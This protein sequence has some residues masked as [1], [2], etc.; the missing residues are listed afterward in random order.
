MAVD[1][2]TIATA[3]YGAGAK[4]PPGPMSQLLWIWDD[5]VAVLPYDTVAAANAL[6]AAG[7][8]RGSDGL[9]RKETRALTFDILV[10]AT[11]VGRRRLAEALQEQWR[12]VG[13]QA[14]VTAA[15]FPVFMERLGKGNFD[16]YIGAWLDEPSPRGLAEQWTRSGVGALNYGHYASPAFDRLYAEAIAAPDVPKARAAWRAAFDALNADA[17]ALFLYAPVNVAAVS[18]RVEG[19][20]VNPYSWLSDLPSLTLKRE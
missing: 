17:P 1:R 8:I 7:W 19:L 14:T 12:K 16:S 15:D 5:S 20:E 4:A 2:T 10:P 9:R 13:V 11:S 18:R 6:D 3:V